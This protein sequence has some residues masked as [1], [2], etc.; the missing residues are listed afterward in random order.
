MFT[1]LAFSDYLTKQTQALSLADLF[2]CLDSF[3]YSVS[4]KAIKLW[5]QPN[6]QRYYIDV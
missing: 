6:Q 4:Q 5:L 2:I 1:A 3:P